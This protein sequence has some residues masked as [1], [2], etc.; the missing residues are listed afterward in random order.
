[1]VSIHPL[2]NRGTGIG[3]TIFRVEIWNLKKIFLGPIFYENSLED[4]WPFWKL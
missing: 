2:S 4:Q 1:M 3:G